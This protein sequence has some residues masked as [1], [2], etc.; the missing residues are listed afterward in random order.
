MASVIN[1]LAEQLVIYRVGVYVALPAGNHLFVFGTHDVI[2]VFLRQ[3]R[4]TESS[5]LLL[6]AGIVPIHID[7]TREDLIQRGGQSRTVGVIT[8]VG[9]LVVQ[10]KFL[11]G[12]GEPAQYCAGQ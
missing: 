7:I 11:G 10:N 3:M 1:E 6:G 12:S 8:T 4:G 2:L 5:L 9:L